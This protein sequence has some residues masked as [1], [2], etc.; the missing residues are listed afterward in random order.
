VALATAWGVFKDTHIQFVGLCYGHHGYPTFEAAKENFPNQ[1]RPYI[2]KFNGLIGDN[3]FMAGD[4]TWIDFAIADFL[5]AMEIFSP[6]L[7]GE[8]PKL[9][10]YR[11]RIWSLPELKDYFSFRFQERP[12]HNYAALWK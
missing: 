11:E 3:H 5:Q 1:I 9:K 7:M 4:I 10:A 2:A 6:S 8:F 12:I